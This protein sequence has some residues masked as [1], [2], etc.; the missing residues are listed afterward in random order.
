MK[1]PESATVVLAA[2]GIPEAIGPVIRDPAVA[3]YAL[4]TR[5]IE[6]DVL[7]VDGR[8]DGTAEVAAGIAAELGLAV[9][10]IPGPPSSPGVA[11]LTGFRQ[12]VAKGRADLVVTLDDNGR[13]DGTQIPRLIDQL[14]EEDLH[15]VIGSRWARGSGTPGLSPR[16]WLL[17]KLANLAFRSLTGTRA[18]ADATT[19]FQVARVQVVRKFDLWQLP[20]NSHSVQT[21][22]VAMA[23]ARG[24]RVGEGL[25]IYRLPAAGNG[26]LRG[27]D[28]GGFAAHLFG[29]PRQVDCIRQRRL[30]PSGRSFED[31]RFGVAGDL[32]RLGTLALLR[33]GAGRVPPVPAGADPLGRTRFLRR[34]GATG[35]RGRQAL[36]A[37]E[38]RPDEGFDA[39]MYLNVLEHI[40]DDA[41]ERRLST[42][43]RRAGGVVILMFGSALKWRYSELNYGAGHYRRYSVRRLGEL[44]AA[45]GLAVVSARYFDVLGILPYLVV[46]RL[47][48]HGDITGSIMWA[49][50]W[51]AAPPVPPLNKNVVHVARK[52]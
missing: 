7:L 29:L 22:F 4:R 10:T 38:V 3:A 41:T 13:H 16:R 9:T 43:A 2:Y 14:I 36:T 52:P 21:A 31:V 25:I 35:R 47:L 30:S 27:R 32:E 37:Y 18:I 8:G 5:S 45:A 26:E 49:Y 1:R 46:Y 39:V 11:Y 17:G 6:L 23:V 20:V 48:W 33:L 15:F 51:D 50:D 28:I 44:A 19:S 24:Y 12:V 42:A 34:A 40:P